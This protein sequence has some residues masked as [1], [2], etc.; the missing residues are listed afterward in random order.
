M[1]IWFW[2]RS[3]DHTARALDFLNSLRHDALVDP[4]VIGRRRGNHLEDAATLL[5][6]KMAHDWIA[7]RAAKQQLYCLTGEVAGA[8]KGD[9]LR[10]PMCSRRA[11]SRSASRSRASNR[12][13]PSGPRRRS[14]LRRNGTMRRRGA[15]ITPSRRMWR[16]SWRRRWRRPSAGC[17]FPS[18]CPCPAP[19]AWAAINISRA[20]RTGRCK[21]TSSGARRNRPRPPPNP[22]KP[23]RRSARPRQRSCWARARPG[24]RCSGRRSRTRP[25]C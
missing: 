21:R 18:S 9:R 10:A 8:P 7:A 12:R 17:P 16:A 22:S 2:P 19:L 5:P 6:G 11:L 15:C 13:S 1:G 24:A 4:W 3:V 20:R 25:S 23:P 14:S